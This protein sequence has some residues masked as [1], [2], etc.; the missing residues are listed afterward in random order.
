MIHASG[1]LSPC[2]PFATRHVRPGKIPYQ[3]REGE[4]A[5]DLLQRL[6]LN[7]GWGEIIGPHGSGKSTLLETLVPLLGEQGKRVIRFSLHDRQR[8]LPVKRA[9]MRNWNQQ[10][11][12]VVDGYE[13]LSWWNRR[14][15]VR[16][17]R[18][19]H[20]GLIVTAHRNMRLPLLYKSQPDRET[21]VDVVEFLL[22]HPIESHQR[23]QIL[24]TFDR[25]LGNVREALFDLYDLYQ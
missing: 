9:E 25:H 1:H 24:D 7:E 6:A 21:F 23:Q 19:Q 13:Q 5:Q 20:L 2:N 14:W 11:I 17:C 22:K 12:V 8:S 15:L 3:F 16:R 18:R 4:C 10:N